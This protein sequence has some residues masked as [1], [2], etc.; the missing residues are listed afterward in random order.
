MVEAL[1]ISNAPLEHP[2]MDYAFLRQ[3]GIQ[4][5][6]KLASDRWTD[7]NAHDPGITILEAWCYALT[8]LSYR[9]DFAMAELLAAPPRESAPPLFLTARESLT[10]APL[11]IN[12]YRK[13]LIDIEGVKNA[14]LEPIA[15][16]APAIYYDAKNAKLTFSNV[17]SL[18]IAEPVYLR[19]LYRV[20]IEA[21]NHLPTDVAEG[22]VPTA[23]AKLHQHRNLCED[24]AEIKLL[25]AETITV[26]AELEIADYVD[27]HHLLAQLYIALEQVISPTLDFLTLPD[28]LATGTPVEEIFVGPPLDHGFIDDAQLNQYAR[29]TELRTSDLIHVILDIDSVKTVKTIALFSS[30]AATPQPWVLDLNPELTPRLQPLREMLGD[31]TL[32]KGQIPCPID[33]TKAETALQALQAA[34]VVPPTLAPD[35]P[36]PTG[37]Y[38]QLADYESLQSE[39]PLIYGIGDLGLPPSASPQRQAQAKQLQAYLMVFDQLLAN[40]FAQLDHL[41]SLFTPDNAELASYFTQSIAH[42]PAAQVILQDPNGYLEN[43]RETSE[44][45]RDR[46]NRLL[47]HLAAQYGESFI[48]YSLLYGNDNLPDAAIEHKAAFNA[49][50]RSISAG[51]AQGFNY[52][53]HPSQTDNVSGLKRRVSRLL[54]IEPQRR[55]LKTNN[56]AETPNIEGFYVIEQ[57]LLRPHSAPTTTTGESVRNDLLSFAK[58]IT[59]Y[60]PT[61]SQ[62]T[63]TSVNHGLQ[64]GETINIIYS[65]DYNGTYTVQSADLTA[66]TFTLD[67]EFRPDYTPDQDAWVRQDQHPDPF[68]FQV[69]IVLPSWPQR[70]STESFRQLVYNTLTAE[71]PAH[72]T[73]WLHW[74]D[75]AQMSTFEVMHDLWLQ[76]LSGT[77]NED[78]DAQAAAQAAAN[79]LIDFLDLGSTDIPEIPPLLGYMTI[80]GDGEDT[81]APEFI[82]S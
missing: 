32:Y 4:L 5:I 73:L 26:H 70:F 50:Y 72:I 71:I 18:N 41:R 9:L 48:D 80:S 19:G 30:S 39:F 23:K 82:V 37:D 10:T 34:R 29:Q 47:D 22:L 21:D 63:C 60:T 59:A 67:A 57:L 44:T 11:T 2:G 66:N 40:Y 69:S 38:R 61:G 55:S 81:P 27:P 76:Q 14:W 52:R 45:A 31:I 53:L 1:K 75:A 15:E 54:G 79:Q 6:A 43:L 16:P 68:S 56:K 51:R 74:L 49:H 3:E 24:F 35:L 65:S 58:P 78:A 36:I 25:Q 46:K 28:L 17:D 12:D 20:L 7:Y 13:L 42:F 8:D 33:P 64:G 77:A 62:V